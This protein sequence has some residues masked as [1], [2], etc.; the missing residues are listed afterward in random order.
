MAHRHSGKGAAWPPFFSRLRL[1]LVTTLIIAGAAS[2]TGSPVP[3]DRAVLADFYF[4]T[5]LTE[6]PPH[7]ETEHFTASLVRYEHD[8]RTLYALIARPRSTMPEGG[9][10]VLVA[11]HGFVP[12][13]PRYG[14]SADG[15][16]KR[17]GDYYRDIPDLFAARGFM[18]VMP[19]YR[20][21][22]ISDGVANQAPDIYDDI[23]AYA[24]DVTALVSGLS[25]LDG[26]DMNRVAF[27]GHSMGGPVAYR[28]LHSTNIVIRAIALWSPMQIRDDVISNPN[29]PTPVQLQHGRDDPVT[30]FANS[31][32]FAKALREASIPVTVYPWDTNAHLFG[33]DDREVAANRDVEFFQ[34]QFKEISP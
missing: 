7:Y 29:F 27:W 3:S 34:Q 25:Q 1:R 11:M 6:A 24:D 16:T 17:P 31:D 8:G 23:A 15:Q 19:D 18:V 2:C 12:E 26:A 20:G 32:G 13:P 21:H 14:V 30:P 33:A 28:A 22:N 9:F 5:E 10:P 4:G